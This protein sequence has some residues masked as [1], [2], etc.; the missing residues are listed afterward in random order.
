MAQ[1]VIRISDREFQW[2]ADEPGDPG[3][4]NFGKYVVSY[5]PDGMAGFGTLRTSLDPREA[6]TFPDGVAAT[7]FWR[8][9]STVLPL[10][11]DG[12]PNRPLTAYSFETLTL[13]D[14]LAGPPEASIGA[15]LTALFLGRNTQ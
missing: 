14:A 5:D 11:P 9:P 12:R 6:I 4:D 1:V 13:E 8:R 7:E 15:L 2:L 3:A 10:R